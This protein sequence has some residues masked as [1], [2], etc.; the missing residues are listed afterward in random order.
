MSNIINKTVTSIVYNVDE[1]TFTI[2]M[3][4]TWNL[5]EKTLTFKPDDL[6]KHYRKSMNP[7][8]GYRSRRP[9]DGDLRFATE[10]ANIKNFIDRQ[11]FDSMIYKIKKGPGNGDRKDVPEI[12]Q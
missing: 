11:F 2:K 7:F 1:N 4:G 10:N 8:I 3:L 9:E 6:V 12:L 5:K